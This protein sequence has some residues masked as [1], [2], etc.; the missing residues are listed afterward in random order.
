MAKVGSIMKFSGAVGKPM[1]HGKVAVDYLLFPT[2][3]TAQE[4]VR[5]SACSKAGYPYLQLAQGKGL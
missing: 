5:C 4:G 1:I 3:T 2:F